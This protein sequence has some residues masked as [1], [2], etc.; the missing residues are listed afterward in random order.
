MRKEVREIAITIVHLLEIAVTLA[1]HPHRDL[2]WVQ[3]HPAG[4]VL[5]EV[6]HQDLLREEAPT[7]A[8]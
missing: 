4:Q 2:R 3:G 5:Q 1:L 6:L 7:L 8:Q